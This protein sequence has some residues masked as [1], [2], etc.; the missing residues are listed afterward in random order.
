[1]SSSGASRVGIDVG[2]SAIKAGRI[3]ADG[4][5][6]AEQ[7]WEAPHF[8]RGPSHV[9]DGIA[10][11]AR[12]LHV[13]R[14]LGIGVPGLLDRARGFLIE[15]PNL[16]SFKAL[17]VQGELAKRLGLEPSHVHVEN[18]ANAAAVGE[19][20][21]GGARGE[22]DALVLTLGTGIGGGLILD[23]KLFAGEGMA[24]EV[25]HVVIDPGGRDCGCGRK[26]CVEQY[27]SATAARRRALEAGLPREAPGDLKLLAERARSD[28]AQERALLFAIGRDL[29]RGLGPVLCLLDIRCF[30]FGGGFSAALDVLEPGIRAG[31]EERS[32]GDRQHHVRLQ[33]AT[34]GPKAGWIGAAKLAFS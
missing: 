4:A 16:P 34:L 15:S 25:G 29:G 20:W 17:D 7:N 10:E 8:E 26:G 18:D 21:L 27:A 33:R 28:G 5:I 3:G 13:E 23:G 22:R 1:M 19:Q 24:G 31:I 32:Y 14:A 6:Q 2:G 30:V 12:G 9:L 11:L